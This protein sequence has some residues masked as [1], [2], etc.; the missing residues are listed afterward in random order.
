MKRT[1]LTISAFALV[2]LGG[3]ALA[4]DVAA[5][6]EGCLD[7]HEYA[8]DFEGVDAAEMEELLT[9]QLDNAKHKATT[10]MSAG[11]VTAIAGYIAAEANK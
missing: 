4:A 6:S 5:L 10:G 7:C 3:T 2:S 1:L 11:Q 9:A 8:A